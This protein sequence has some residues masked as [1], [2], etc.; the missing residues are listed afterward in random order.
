MR[1]TYTLLVDENGNYV[2]D[3][4]GRF[5]IAGYHEVGVMSG[6]GSLFSGR[7]SLL[8]G[9]API[10]ATGFQPPDTGGEENDLGYGFGRYG[11]T[12]YQDTLGSGAYQTSQYGTATY[13]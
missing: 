12:R 4:Q 9:R 11:L 6:H 5:V 3:D 8:K 2:V 13:Y 1:Y 10:F 7:A